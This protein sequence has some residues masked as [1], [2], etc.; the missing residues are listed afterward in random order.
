MMRVL[1]P[2]Y[3]MRDSTYTYE[4]TEELRK[5]CD[6]TVLCRKG[7]KPEGE[8][9]SLWKDILYHRADKKF[10]APFVYA[11]SLMA[12][13]KEIRT[14]HYDVVHVQGFKREESEI[15]L[16]L[17]EKA[18]GTIPFLVHTVH[19]V[20]PH[21][22]GEKQRTRYFR[23]YE[24][25]DLLVVHNEYS[26]KLL[27][28]SGIPEKK[29]L[30]MPHGTYQ[31][32]PAPEKGTEDGRIHFLQFG[33][34]RPYK[35]VDILLR[36]VHLLPQDVRKKI[37]VTVIGR[38]YTSQ[39]PTDYQQMI[40]DLQIED[41][42]SVKERFMEPEEVGKFFGSADFCLFPYRSI[43]GSGALM[44]AYTYE[45][46]VIASAIP[47][48]AEE[49]ENGKTG[50]LFAPEDERGLAEAIRAA[51]LMPP[52]VLQEKKREIAFLKEQKYSWPKSAA[53]LAGA[54]ENMAEHS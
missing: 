11:E 50:I 40:R 15:P 13:K 14:G 51:V 43:F 8:C 22:N 53:L 27:E 3:F 41:C 39:D 28:K 46:P 49:T 17:K 37:R 38:H 52:S 32:M 6:L 23:F 30:V 16:Y 10:R 18:A 35:G 24:A 42:V 12:L 9:H 29:I 34:L 19:N 54:Y 26:R 7:M 36:A 5:F 33:I 47:A 48:F 4:L 1:M 25:C 45:K 20:L 2:E 31:Y 21:E 44:M